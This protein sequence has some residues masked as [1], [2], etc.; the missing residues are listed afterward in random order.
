MSLPR[1][2]IESGFTLIELLVVIAIIAV[3]AAM[4]LPALSRAK[5]AARR[6]Q[7]LNNVRQVTLA[8]VMYA[9]DNNSNPPL[10]YIGPVGVSDKNGGGAQYTALY[11]LP[12][13]SIGF[14]ALAEKYITDYSV[15]FC[16]SM[17]NPPYV[18]RNY[19]GASL[20]LTDARVAYGGYH[21][22]Y[23]NS[24]GGS[25]NDPADYVDPVSLSVFR[26]PNL[27]S[28][29]HTGFLADMFFDGSPYP[30]T[31]FCHKGGYNV[32]Y[33]D[34]SAAFVPDTKNYI[35]TVINTYP[36]DYYRTWYYGWTGLL[37]Q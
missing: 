24:K 31:T 19:T 13:S 26:H 25:G 1:H 16:P 20:G 29:G 32:G 36:G 37:N 7:C 30:A 15:W 35:Q 4:L 14:F 2:R 33:Y 18:N 21:Y 28:A 22:S 12:F 27:Q 11:G 10:G 23:V 17:Q 5:E 8:M 9:G 34:G 6:T 3:L